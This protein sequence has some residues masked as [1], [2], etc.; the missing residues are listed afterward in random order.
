MRRRG[1]KG[2]IL[3]SKRRFLDCRVAMRAENQKCIS[4]VEDQTTVGRRRAGGE[5][6][7]WRTALALCGKRPSISH[8]GLL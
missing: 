6:G 3:G 5:G 1:G 4:R 7:G 2:E 8:A